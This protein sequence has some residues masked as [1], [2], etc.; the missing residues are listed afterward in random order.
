MLL[1]KFDKFESQALARQAELKAE[2]EE[3]ER[4]RQE[5]LKK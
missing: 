5:K 1:E 2:R 4:R 3:E